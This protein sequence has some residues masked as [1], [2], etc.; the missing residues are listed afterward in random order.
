MHYFDY[1]VAPSLN[2]SGS[3]FYHSHVGFQTVSATGPLLVEEPD[4]KPP[5]Q[6]DEERIFFLTELYNKSD[7][8]ITA[9]LTAAPFTW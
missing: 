7:E 8:Q 1:E 3:Y 6:Y 4:G 9:G 2:E 5:Y